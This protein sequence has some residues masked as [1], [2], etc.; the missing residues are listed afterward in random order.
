MGYFKDIS[1]G[2]FVNGYDNPGTEETAHMLAGSGQGY[3]D[4]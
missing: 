3:R 4:I 1:F 2:V